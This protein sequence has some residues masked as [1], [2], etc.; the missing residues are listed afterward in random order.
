MRTH[1][2]ELADRS[3]HTVVADYW[4]FDSEDVLHFYK[5]GKDVFHRQWKE[6]LFIYTENTVQE[7]TE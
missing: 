7:E 5:D 3:E 6:I 2:I 1:Y 4:K